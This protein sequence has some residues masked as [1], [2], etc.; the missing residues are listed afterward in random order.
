M[1]L[2]I[3]ILI[4]LLAMSWTSNARAQDAYKFV[5]EY[6]RELGAIEGIRANGERELKGKS[7]ADTL[8]DCIRNSERMQLELGSQ[9]RILQSNT[10]QPQ[11][12]DLIPTILK[13]Y[14]YKLQIWQKLS[15][16]CSALIAGPQPN[17]DYGK[18]AADAPKLTAQLE[19]I[20]KAIF[21]ATP[22]I[23]ATLIDMKP[24]AQNHVNHLIITKD[25]RDKLVR[26]I[27]LSFGKKLDEA[28]QNYT[29][30]TASVLKGYLAEKGYK[31]SDEP[32]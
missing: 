16:G 10:L 25:E 2:K 29:V 20:D 23:F 14:D 32:W 11:F 1:R 18:I 17:V 15:D 27:V 13:Y 22:L 28:N 9:I 3:I 26:S 6:V 30:S 24:D 8:S 19:Y 7:G 21:E 5:S 12:K 31:C 4:L